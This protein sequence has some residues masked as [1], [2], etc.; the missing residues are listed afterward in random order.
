MQFFQIASFKKN[1]IKRTRKI[2]ERYFIKKVKDS[3]TYFFMNNKYK[4]I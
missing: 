1:F 2:S 3:F 4:K